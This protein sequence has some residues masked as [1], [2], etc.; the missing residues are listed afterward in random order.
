MLCSNS[1]LPRA[2]RYLK[3]I[4]S[5]AKNNM[6]PMKRKTAMVISM[7]MES[8]FAASRELLV[9]FPSPEHRIV[10]LGAFVVLSFSTLSH[11]SKDLK[12]STKIPTSV[13]R[14]NDC[15]KRYRNI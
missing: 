12:F 3:Y 14:L 9:K 15:V 10:K 7:V 1:G 6:I 5:C 2:A 11:K 8:V 13:R 4:M